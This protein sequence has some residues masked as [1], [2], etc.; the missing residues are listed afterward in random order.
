MLVS[1]YRMIETRDTRITVN[2]G[3]GILCAESV[4]IASADPD[5][6]FKIGCLL[7]VLADDLRKAQ[8]KLK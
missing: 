5:E 6:L 3:H 8:D 4:T 1:Q 7:Q 2:N